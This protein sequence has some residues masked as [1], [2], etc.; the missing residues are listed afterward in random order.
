[1]KLAFIDTETTGLD[2][3][4]SAV[5]E[6]AAIIVENG[7]LLEQ[8]ETKIKPTSVELFYA[9]PKA[10]EINGYTP[11]AWFDAPPMREVGPKIIALLDGSILVGHNVSFDEVMLTSNL[12]L[13][14]VEGR[15]PYQKIDTQTLV[16]EHLWPLGLKR[17]SLDSVRD[18]LGWSK[19]GAHTAMGDARDAKRLFDLLWRKPP[20][21]EI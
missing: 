18:F 4:T 9:L 7:V 17:A 20:Q 12:K 10:L 15:I 2:Y 1:M 5:L 11:K 13:H 6:F 14:G 8:Y 19:V 16:M 21:R 3:S